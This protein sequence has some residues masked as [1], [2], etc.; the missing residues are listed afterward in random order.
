MTTCEFRLF[1]TP[2]GVCG[3]VWS[4]RGI[5][6]VQLPERDAMRT[7]ARVLRRFPG[8]REGQPPPGVQDALERI[9]ALLHGEASDLSP[10][11]LDVSEVSDFHRRVY[12]VARTIPPGGTL[13]YGDIATRLGD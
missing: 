13:T 12:E 4:E 6:G 9:M 2:I 11:A 1:E 3:I 5:A 8:A 10:I 7:P